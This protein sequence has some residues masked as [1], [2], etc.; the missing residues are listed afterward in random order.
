MR[1]PAGFIVGGVI[2]VLFNEFF[3]ASTLRIVLIGSRD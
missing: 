3:L 2:S 1:D